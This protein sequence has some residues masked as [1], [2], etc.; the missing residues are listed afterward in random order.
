MG[1]AELARKPWQKLDAQTKSEL[2][3]LALGYGVNRTR[4]RFCFKTLCGALLTP[5][6]II[7]VCSGSALGQTPIIESNG[8]AVYD[9]PYNRGASR[10]RLVIGH[11]RGLM[12]PF[13]NV[14]GQI[15]ALGIGATGS[16]P[17][18][19]VARLGGPDG[20]AAPSFQIALARGTYDNPL[21]VVSGDV[22]GRLVADGYA[23]S[24]GNM[25]GL[26][27][28]YFVCKGDHEHQLPGEIS[29]RTS[30]RST[31]FVEAMRIDENQYV[32]VARNPTEAGHVATKAYVDSLISLAPP[33][34]GDVH[35][36]IRDNSPGLD[37][38]AEF[39]MSDDEDS[40]LRI[41]NNTAASGRFDPLFSAMP[42]TLLMAEA[43]SSLEKSIPR[44]T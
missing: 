24:V 29:F 23:E 21:S 20:T 12:G 38:L 30:S 25:K 37:A 3:Q 40:H 39:A 34:E 17:R 4:R 44:M 31:A 14:Q 16:V 7:L 10:G 26:A 33:Q 22:V 41:F 5:F 35:E 36:V 43:C 13:F 42:I 28:I 9:V 1:L 27:G 15:E 18:I 19:T 11:N 6:I 8:N 32:W 2:R